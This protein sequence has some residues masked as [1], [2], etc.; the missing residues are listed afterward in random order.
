MK[1]FKGIIILLVTQ[2]LA[3]ISIP[4][5]LGFLGYLIILQ[6]EK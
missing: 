2:F 6:T 4:M 5:A 3:N 1:I